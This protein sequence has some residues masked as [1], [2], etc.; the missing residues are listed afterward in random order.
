MTRRAR[1]VYLG[2]KDH[3]EGREEGQDIVLTVDLRSPRTYNGWNIEEAVYTMNK[4]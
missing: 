1:R 2:H 3:M 4:I